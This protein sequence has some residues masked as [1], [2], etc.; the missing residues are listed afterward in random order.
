MQQM[1]ENVD[2]RENLSAAAHLIHGSSE[3]RFCVT[4]APGGLTREEIESVGYHYADC[5]EMLERYDPE[6]LSD[7][8]NSDSE[9]PFYYISNPALGLWAHQSR[10]DG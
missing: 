5:S 9:G 2:L 3:N 8:W 4:Y 6:Q 7:G 1:R 10:L